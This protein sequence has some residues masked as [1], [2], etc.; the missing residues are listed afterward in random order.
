MPEPTS[1]YE[2]LSVTLGPPTVAPLAGAVR[3]P[4]GAVLSTR[5][6]ERMGLVPV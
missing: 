1:E 3:E 4:A 2:P 6:F 5:T